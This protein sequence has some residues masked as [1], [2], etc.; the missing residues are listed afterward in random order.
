MKKLWSWL[1]SI[2]R[3]TNDRDQSCTNQKKFKAG[4]NGFVVDNSTTY[5]ITLN[6]HAAKSP[7]ENG[8]LPQKK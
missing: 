8:N 2:F 3:P 5:N 1:K 6:F 4:D 7:D